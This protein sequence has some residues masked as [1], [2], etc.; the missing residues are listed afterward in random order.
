MTARRP[1]R[2]GAGVMATNRCG[3]AHPVV[4][5]VHG[6]EEGG[7][8]TQEEDEDGEASSQDEG[9]VPFA[10]AYGGIMAA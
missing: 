8:R 9:M 4:E 3:V 5:V 10:L 1:D 2:R 7:D 6:E